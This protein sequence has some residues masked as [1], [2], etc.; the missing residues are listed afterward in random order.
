MGKFTAVN[1]RLKNA[2][3]LSLPLQILLVRW[4]RDYPGFIEQ[5][6]SR[7]LYPYIASALRFLYGWIPF[8]IGDIVYTLLIILGIRYVVL[9]WLLIR[10]KPLSFIR[11]VFL[12]ASGAYLTFH[13]LWGLNYY[14]EPLS[15]TLDLK[16]TCTK[17]EL[18]EFTSRLLDR[19]NTLQLKLAG[20]DSV[21]VPF[22]FRHGEVFEKISSDYHPIPGKAPFFE[23]PDPSIKTS[24]YSLA[25]TYMGYGGYLNPFTLEAQVNRKIPM[26]RFPVVSCHEIAH[27]LGYAAEN[28]ANFIGYLASL[29]HRD[30]RVRY[31][32][33]SYALGYCLSELRNLD[34]ALF[35]ELYARVHRGVQM[36]YEALNDF[37]TA[38]ENPL[39]PV[40]KN[41]FD[42]FLKANNQAA[43]IR[44]YNLV[45]SLLVSYHERY[46]L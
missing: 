30:A 43:G 16:D 24:L 37:W 26:F 21:Q 44:S 28:E 40:F 27:Q 19:T 10:A 11:N 29:N 18:V 39:E 32:A 14:R 35:K 23:Y 22:P 25:L 15:K 31:A 41:T 5:Y 3:A 8:S 7:G 2:I 46:P 4:A 42:A 1:Y 20:S 12:V 38:Y 13:L 34:D 45:V 9:N 36:D 6:Y 17:E 33:H